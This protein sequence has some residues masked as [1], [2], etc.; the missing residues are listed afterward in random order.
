M[1]QKTVHKKATYGKKF[2]S[3]VAVNL[4]TVF[5]ICFFSPMEIYLGNIVEFHFSANSAA[6]ILAIFSLAVSIILSVIFAFLPPKVLRPVNLSVFSAGLCVYIQSMLLN[7]SMGSLTGEEDV[8][9]PTLII[10]NI[11]IWLCIFALI[12]GAWF[13]L[14][15]FK[16]QKYM[17]SGM[18]FLS[19]ALIVMQLVGFLSLF[20]T[21]D[22]SINALKNSYFTD[23]GKFELSENENVI[24]FIIDTCDNDLVESALEKYPDMFDGFDGFTYYPNMSTTHS[25]TYPSLPYLLTGEI[26]YF[27]KPYTQ[28]VNEAY[29]NSSFID[30]IDAL[31]TDIRIYT[32]GQYIGQSV[33]DKID[34]Y[35]QYDSS[36]ISA[37]NITEFLK[38]SIKVSAYRGTPYAVKS[39]FKY[40][41]SSVNQSSMKEIPGKAVL[42]D[43]VG[44]Y[45]EI[46]ND[47]IT[48]NSKTE[49]SFRFYHLYGTHGGASL[50]QNCE[51]VPNVSRVDATRG[52]LRLVEE[53]ITQMKKQ[54][55]F[56]NSTIIITADHGYSANS[57]DLKLPFATSCIMM[58]KPAN[59]NDS[60]PMKTSNAPVCHQDLFS[61]V[62]Q[63]LGGNSEKYGRAIWNIAENEERE[64]KYYHTALYS[65]EDGEVALR[66]YS[67]IGDARK[68]ESYHLTGKYWDVIYSERAVSKHR[69]SEEENS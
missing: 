1:S 7:G 51:Y 6:I 50:D 65:D 67:I 69:L 48:V 26:C 42:F 40:T 8:Y 36:K 3:A 22:N 23:D 2:F 11:A 63:S 60:E 64:R 10:A 66:E 17:F 62:I 15:K 9:S 32:E 30:D 56:D 44:F 13:L 33:T 29:E 20:T 18:R 38:Q 55:V 59:T 45:N 57:D 61:T 37:M 53:Y 41:S 34:N 14:Q 31:N 68:L 35:V 27:D 52:C 16:K 39:K 58:V 19:V 25:R 49:K 21:T 5:T 54:G 47:G 24:Y 28:Y 4:F 46:K 12:F 43:D